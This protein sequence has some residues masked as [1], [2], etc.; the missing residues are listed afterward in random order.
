MRAIRKIDAR[1]FY[2]LFAP[3]LGVIHKN[4]LNVRFF[5]WNHSFL[6]IVRK[7]WGK[8]SNVDF[9]SHYKG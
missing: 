7:S 9:D 6:W 1:L 3:I 2:L 8:A 5:I 4:K